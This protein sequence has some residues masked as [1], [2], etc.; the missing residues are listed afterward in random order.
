[1][2]GTFYFLPL[3]QPINININTNKNNKTNGNVLNMNLLILFTDK[4]YLGRS[5][6]AGAGLT[7][8]CVNKT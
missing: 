5:T 4:L 3:T 2:V 8:A 1:M 7:G 6:S